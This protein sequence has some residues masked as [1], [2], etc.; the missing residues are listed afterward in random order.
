MM[1]RFELGK[2]EEVKEA[3]ALSTEVRSRVHHTH[4]TRCSPS[5]LLDEHRACAPLTQPNPNPMAR[6]R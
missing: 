1:S 3:W 4:A 5:A 2:Y 6:R